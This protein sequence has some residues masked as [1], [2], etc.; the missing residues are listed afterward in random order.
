MKLR[1]MKRTERGTPNSVRSRVHRQGFSLIEMIGVLAVIAIVA[2]ML[3]PAFVKRIDRAAR[4]KET[5]DLN[6]IGAAYIQSILRNKTIPGNATWAAAVSSQMSLPVSAIASN[7]RRNARFFFSDPDLRISGAALPYAQTTNGS[8]MKPVSPRVMIISSLDPKLPLPWALTNSSSAAD[9]TAIWNAGED[10]IPAAPAF[11]GW[12]GK[13]EDLR[14]KKLNLEPLFH[15]L[16]LINHDTTVLPKFDIDNGAMAGV[17]N[18]GTGWNSYYLDGSV[19]GLRS[20]SGVI[21]TRYLMKRSISF[22][23][24]SGSWLGQV[25]GGQPINPLALDFLNQ[26]TAF[27]SKAQSAQGISSGASQFSV[28]LAVY[29]FMYDYTLWANECPHFDDHGKSGNSIPEYKMLNDQGQNSSGNV[30]G[31]S[32]GL[33]K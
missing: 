14:I 30:D 1:S 24:E 4:T 9:F 19:L 2:A 17:T 22:V 12:D 13:G 15:Q 23:F 26:A 21:Q 5:A 32:T 25:Q 6:A 33:V 28:L 7:A 10:T 8:G 11:A 29:T 27:M 3:A 31:F 18:S 20:A 16:I